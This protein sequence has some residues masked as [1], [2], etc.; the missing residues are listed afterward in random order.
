LR[1]DFRRLAPFVLVF[2]SLIVALAGSELVLQFWFPIR[3]AIYQLDDRYLFGY[4]PGSRK[5]TN[6]PGESWPKTLVRINASGR[7]GTDVDL[8]RAV[9]RVIVYGDSFIAAEFS[10]DRDTYPVQ[11]AERLNRR[12]RL[13]AVLNAGVTGYGVDQ[14]SLRIED[15]LRTL[16]P[17]LIIVAVY[18]GNDFGDLL[19]D[20]LYRLD[21]QGKTVRNVP[22]IAPSLQLAFDAPR[23]LSRIQLVRLLQTAFQ[24]KDAAV[25]NAGNDSPEG[26][27]DRQL[28]NRTAEYEDYVLKGD[29]LVR[30]LLADEYDA[31]VSV[32]PS[33]PSST[34]RLQM[35]AGVL[36]RIRELAAA[37][38]AALL[39]LVIP[40]R[41][42]VIETCDA[43]IERRR[44]PDYRASG[45]TDRVTAIG[46]SLGVAVLDLFPA[47]HADSPA[48]WYDSRTLHW[49]AAGQALAARLTADLI[50]QKRLLQ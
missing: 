2:S 46:R 14:E 12:S 40:E 5:L 11:L 42:D 30:N 13:T 34:Y 25:A 31:D 36:T 22:A 48:Q 23:R 18:A 35:M 8:P 29:N 17:T 21:D 26:A 9:N 44:Y 15:D 50:A 4:I 41:C 43:L 6:R 7:R 27:L 47:F 33:A 3:G 1:I 16:H 45:L 38:G 19:R 24:P 39:L 20:K 10:P 37:H 32:V 28:A 49:N